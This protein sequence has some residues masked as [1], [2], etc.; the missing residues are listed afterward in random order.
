MKEI[1]I[2]NFELSYDGMYFIRWNNHIIRVF[3]ELNIILK[4][5]KIE[6]LT[7]DNVNDIISSW[8][9]IKFNKVTMIVT[10]EDNEG[11]LTLVTSE[12]SD[13]YHEKRSLS[14]ID[15]NLKDDK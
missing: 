14:L 2:T 5:L 12:F 13:E 4:M 1:E 8:Q 6:G 3:L 11:K 9:P 10:G 15:I 7:H